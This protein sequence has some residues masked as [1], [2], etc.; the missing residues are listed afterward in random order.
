MRKN[1]WVASPFM[2]LLVACL[3]AMSIISYKYSFMI[4]GIELAVSIVL[5]FALAFLHIRFKLH[6]LTALRSAK[7]VLLMENQQSLDEFSLPL[8]ITSLDGD[9]IWANNPFKQDISTGNDVGG[10][11]IAKYIYPKTLRQLSG[12]KSSNV[13][14]K[15]RQYTVYSIKT[16]SSFVLYF[17]DDTFYKQI[18]KEYTE[19]KIVI[20]VISFDN[21]EELIRES[22]G[23]EESR[24]LLQVEEELRLWSKE[25]G[26]FVRKLSNGRYMLVFEDMYVDKARENRFDVL[27][28]V[29]KI[30]N[31]KG[32]SAT[33]SVGIGRGAKS[34]TESENWAKQALDMALGRGGDQVAIMKKDGSYEFFGGLS[35]GIEKRDKVRTRVIAATLQD[36][37][38]SADKVFIMGHR[39]SDLDSMGA[40]IGVWATAS[41]GVK[42]NAFIVVNK[43]QSLAMSLVEAMEEKYPEK[44]IFISPA[45]CLQEVS[46][47]TLVV[48]VDTHSPSFVECPDL[49]NYAGSIVIIDHH[50]MMVQYIKNSVIFYHEPYASSASEMVAELIQYIDANALEAV[51]AQALLAGIMLD[52]KNFVLKTGVRTF[53]ASAFLRRRGADTVQVKRYF[54]NTLATYK[55]K[56]ALVANSEIYKNCAMAFSKESSSGTRIAAAQAADE[57]L[58]I[59]NVKA[60]FVMFQDNGAINISGRSLGDVN[61]QVILEV[62]GGGGHLTMA[63]A[64]IKGVS[65]EEARKAL[66]ETLND[67][68]T[69]NKENE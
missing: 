9:I 22:S 69:F 43:N 46:E 63:G 68:L 14:I 18:H 6:T 29:R 45:E 13:Q 26:G 5:S 50:R 62:F 17:V 44:R 37:I 33:V 27:D 30:K 1:M 8:V 19:K 34:G 60:S 48:V 56:S 66:I 54:A 20:A 59:Q 15:N 39:F 3:F 7:K 61:V 31:G 32:M 11:S 58:S 38:K 16:S 41:K 12:E 52:T 28:K 10:L 24:I 49:L 65:M 40:A 4:F 47:K 53:E 36:H 42:K 57:L 23:G 25:M 64:Q 51:E 55:E 2:Y 21:R 35:K 67:K